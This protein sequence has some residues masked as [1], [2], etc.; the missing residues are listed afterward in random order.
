[1]GQ[2]S[3]ISGI[4]TGVNRLD[5]RKQKGSSAA[6]RKK[7]QYLLVSVVFSFLLGIGLLMGAIYGSRAHAR[8]LA[9]LYLS[10]VTWE[11]GQGIKTTDSLVE[12][13]KNSDEKMIVFIQEPGHYNCRIR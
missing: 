10:D 11:F 3:I 7:Q 9:E 2:V 1:M 4:V 8:H 13:L 5:Y 6:V 12:L